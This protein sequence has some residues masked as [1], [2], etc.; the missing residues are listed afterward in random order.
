MPTK[1]QWTKELLLAEAQKFTDKKD[2]RTKA[3]GAYIKAYRLGILDEC[4]THMNQSRVDNWTVENIK[5]I[6]SK[7]KELTIFRKEN[8]AAYIW[9]MRNG[10]A[11]IFKELEY[12]RQPKHNHEEILELAKQFPTKLEFQEHHPQLAK[13]SARS[14]ELKKVFPIIPRTKK[15]KILKGRL[16]YT[17]EEIIQE[18]QRYAN[19]SE[20]RKAD[21]KIFSAMRKRNLQ[22][23]CFEGSTGYWSDDVLFQTASK[24]NNYSDFRK[25]DYGACLALIKRNLYKQATEHFT[26]L[27]NTN[28]TFQDAK[29][30][31]SQCRSRVEFQK[32][33]KALYAKSRKEGWLDELFQNIPHRSDSEGQRILEHILRTVF[34]GDI[35]YNYRK[36]L[37]NRWE[38]DI[39]LP[40]YK[41]G[42]EYDGI[43][44]HSHEKDL[45]ASKRHVADEK[46]ILLLQ[47]CEGRQRHKLPHIYGEQIKKLLINLLPAINPHINKNILPQEIE[48]VI[49]DD[50]LIWSKLGKDAHGTRRPLSS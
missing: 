31:V 28:W 39:Y 38:I 40:D 36:A 33:F 4:C 26:P 44:W 23:R 25:N 15:V 24:Y 46:G 6:A 37:M 43:Y 10:C 12:R 9:G 7:Y 30:A 5:E 19:A 13:A 14:G 11:D 41:L 32:R 21:S 45:F 48:D 50:I 20:L 47:I 18:A 1:K 29:Q 16:K 49:I 27:I 8:S 22:E 2:F 35:K 17:D 3:V 34:Q 42:F